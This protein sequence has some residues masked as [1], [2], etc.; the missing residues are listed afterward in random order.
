MPSTVIRAFS[1][2]AGRQELRVTFLSGRR[3]VYREVPAQTYAAMKAA[4]SKG[5]FFNRHIRD[6]FAFARD[7]EEMPVSG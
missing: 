6:R 4:F 7:D 3:Y 1:Y 5:T 2:D